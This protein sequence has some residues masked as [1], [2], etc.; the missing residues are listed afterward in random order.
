[1]PPTVLAV[2]HVSAEPLGTIGTALAA[3]EVAIRPVRVDRG[4]TVPRSAEGLRGVVIMGGPMGVYEADRHAFLR[5]EL[6]LL[7]D[8]LKR[9]LPILGICLG[10]Q[11]LAA[12]LGSRVFPSGIQEIGWHPLTLSEEGAADSLFRDVPQTFQAFHW[13]G[14]TFDLPSGA[15]RLGSSAKTVEQGF[16]FGPRAYGLQF[17]LEVTEPVVRAMVEGADAELTRAGTTSAALLNGFGRHGS[18]LRTIADTVFGRWT[19]LVRQAAS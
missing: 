11:L 4:E 18:A 6:A 7:E 14:D 3:S 2:Q 12:A 1:M 17:H 5:D 15:I 16:R 9:E 8:A 10:S 19:A 13:H